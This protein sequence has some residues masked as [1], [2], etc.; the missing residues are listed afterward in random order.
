MQEEFNFT[1]ENTPTATKLTG[2][3]D[4]IDNNLSYNPNLNGNSDNW[5]IISGSNATGTS[6]DPNA[7]SVILRA[8][9]NNPI[10]KDGKPVTVTLEKVLSSPDI[11]LAQMLT[12]LSDEDIYNYANIVEITGINSSA[13]SDRIRTNDSRYIF[14][15]G[16]PT[17]TAKSGELIIHPPTG[18]SSINIMYY[19]IVTV[20]LVI[21]A[22]GVFSIK[23]FVLKK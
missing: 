10:I 20:G 11:S 17:A 21:I 6:I 7:H 2:L 4:F 22:V 18:N 14:L 1:G 19:A 9:E 3:I 15:L 16:Q 23:K 13:Q 5:E 12:S 8:K